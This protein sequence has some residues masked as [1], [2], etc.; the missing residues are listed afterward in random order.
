MLHESVEIRWFCSEEDPRVLA[1]KRWF[2]DVKAE[3]E[4]HDYYVPTS[5]GDLGI[6]IRDEKDQTPKGET[7]FL[8]KDEGERVLGAQVRGRFERWKKVSM[9]LA[10]F[11]RNDRA[12]LVHIGK[13]RQ[14]RKFA[15]E[16]GQAKPVS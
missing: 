9:E 7:K 5:R 14:L 4:R 13:E 12:S 2:E 15:F 1:F 10:D 11:S 16:G 8:V 3:G 6:K